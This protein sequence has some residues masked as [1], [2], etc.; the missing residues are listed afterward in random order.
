MALPLP[1]RGNEYYQAPRLSGRS[2]ADAV[3]VAEVEEHRGRTPRFR[4]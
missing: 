1:S 3:L 2:P 4:K